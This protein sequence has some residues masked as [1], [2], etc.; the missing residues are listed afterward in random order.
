[1]AQAPPL[2]TSTRG[3]NIIHQ[4]FKNC[5]TT[6]EEHSFYRTNLL[7]NIGKDIWLRLADYW[8]GSNAINYSFRIKEMLKFIQAKIPGKISRK[9]LAKEF[10]VTPEHLNFIFKNET[11][12]TPVQAIH[13]ARIK[14]ACHFLLEDGLSIKETAEKVGFNDEFYFSK[15]FKKVM[16]TTPG[17]IVGK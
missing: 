11:G 10:S 4:L 8:N 6:F 9:E 12:M 17:K 15:V 14:L 7:E 3:N 2:I 1:M 16:G 5:K 13:Q